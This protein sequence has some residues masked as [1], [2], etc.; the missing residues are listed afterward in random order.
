MPYNKNN[1]DS[2]DPEIKF[3]HIKNKGQR[4]YAIRQWHLAAA[5][6]AMNVTTHRQQLSTPAHSPVHSLPDSP[7]QAEISIDDQIEADVIDIFNNAPPEFWAEI[8]RLAEERIGEQVHPP[9][10][11]DALL[12]AGPGNSM[13]H[14]DSAT[15]SADSSSVG[16]N[17]SSAKR[18]R[19]ENTDGAASM[20]VSSSS[21]ASAPGTGGDGAGGGIGGASSGAVSIPRP[22]DFT[23]WYTR[24]FK[25]Q[26]KCLS[27]GLANQIFKKTPNPLNIN[28]PTYYFLTTALAEIPVDRLYYYLNKNEFNLLAPGETCVK[29]KVSVTQRNIRQSFQTNATS[30]STATLNQNKNAMIAVGLNKTGYGL[31]CQLE[32]GSGTDTMMPT[33]VNE[34]KYADD[35]FLYGVNNTETTFDSTLPLHQIGTYHLLPNYFCMSTHNKTTGG[36]PNLMKYVS[37]YDAANKVGQNIIEYEYEPKQGILKRDPQYRDFGNPSKYQFTQIVPPAPINATAVAMGSKEIALGNVFSVS[38]MTAASSG[39]TTETTQALTEVNDSLFGYNQSIEKSQFIT[40]GALSCQDARIQPS[41]HV[42][43][44]AAPALTTDAFNNNGLPTEWVDVQAYYDITFE[45]WTKYRLHCEFPHGESATAAHIDIPYNERR[46]YNNKA[47]DMNNTTFMG[48]YRQDSAKFV[49][50]F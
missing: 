32:F 5:R 8:D 41:L 9:N 11:Q 34:P 19:V 12:A 47:T 29:V 25:K 18:P 37:L 13:V 1:W 7:P 45:M 27:F 23:G 50:N 30:A 42:G 16:N 2:T 35:Q 28:S 4:L 49:N 6:R 43:V 38:G 14:T 17:A 31:N 26:F 22:H 33:G 3:A 44:E 15:N 20:D 36:W 21:G 24:S 48:L 40:T 39:L 46:F 10:Q